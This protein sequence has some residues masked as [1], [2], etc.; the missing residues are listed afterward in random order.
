MITK[1]KMSA[2][3]KI[4]LLLGAVFSILGWCTIS[5]FDYPVSL[6]PA[7]FA[8][9]GTLAVLMVLVGHAMRPKTK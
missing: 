9:V 8:V 3:N 2:R 7:S 4:I 6:I 5:L 1:N